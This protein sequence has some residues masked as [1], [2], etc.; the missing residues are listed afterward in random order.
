MIQNRIKKIVI[1][2]DG[3]IHSKHAF[4]MALNLAQK[5]NSKLI[6]V[7][8]VEKINGSWY[9]KEFAPSYNKDV[10]RYKEK[11]LRETSK[12]EEISKKKK[13]K[14][15]T[16]IFV[17]DSIVEQILSFSKSNNADVIVMGSHG[18]SGID[19]LILGSVANGVVQRS[20]IPVLVVR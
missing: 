13:I 10:K 11:I 8:C 9:G 16:K 17:T 14:T 3:S 19:K 18:R 5:Y 20:K 1:P 15:M 6:L 7:T 2:F 4:N 12:L